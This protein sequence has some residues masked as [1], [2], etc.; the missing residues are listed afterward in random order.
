MIDIRAS[1]PAWPAQNAI[2]PGLSLTAAESVPSLLLTQITFYYL[3]GDLIDRW[4]AGGDL[5]DS[6]RV[7]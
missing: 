5:N 7:K 1:S 3:E 2:P 4:R 6:E